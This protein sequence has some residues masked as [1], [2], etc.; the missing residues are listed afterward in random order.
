M[1]KNTK[2]A[3]VNTKIAA[4]CGKLLKDDDYRK[5]IQ[6]SSPSEIAMYLKNN[7]SYAEFFK[8]TDPSK[9][10]RDA[11]EKIL[12]ECLVN[13]MDKLIN[14]F[15][16]EYRSFIKCFYMRYEIVDLKRIAR[17]IYIEKDFEDL[18]SNMVFVG[19]YRYVDMD[20]V[21]KAKS[22][23]ELI[24][25]LKDTVYYEYVKGL[26][27]SDHDDSLYRFE[28]ELDRAFFNELSA[29]S[30]KLS[31]T[32]QKAFKDIIGTDA[33]MLNLQWIYRGKKYYN[34][35]PEEIFNYSIDIGC[36]FNYQDIKK[37]CYMNTMD[38]FVNTVKE[39]TP[40]EFMFKND[41]R[42]DIYMERRMRRY[43]YH[44]IMNVRRRA[45]L[46]ISMTLVYIELIEDELQDITSVIEDVRY[47][48][49]YEEAKRYL[50]TVI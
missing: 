39:N 42:Q 29:K 17:L 23:R 32:D 21:I 9:L 25:A 40:Y 27:D 19:K 43:L 34:L 4:M 26:I 13:Y 37:L 41:S 47:N 8:E 24:M 45:K 35:S 46:D 16:G 6:M 38:E 28:M 5:M 12:H 31:K 20:N 22:I 1:D 10:H 30:K 7:T 44:K 48:L 2:Y 18:K 3:A 50:I 33:D 15:S 11:I 36:K 49:D 14:Y